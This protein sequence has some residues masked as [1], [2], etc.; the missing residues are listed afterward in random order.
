LASKTASLQRQDGRVVCEHLLVAARP[1]Q[2]MRGLLGRASL[3][4]DEGILLRPAGSVHT[5][6][7]RFA[8]DVIFLDSD[9][10]VIGIAP[11]LAPWRTAGRK[12]AK[13]VV[14]LAGGECARRGIA[15][16]DKLAVA[17]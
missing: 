16:G 3:A 7:M 8:I 11:E 2:R 10:V 14:E 5:F 12:G 13:A 15:P 17:S 9:D 4:E 6:F 1:H